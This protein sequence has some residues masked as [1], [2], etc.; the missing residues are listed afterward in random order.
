MHKS[1]ITGDIEYSIP[2]GVFCRP[3]GYTYDTLVYNVMIRDRD[4][5]GDGDKDK[6]HDSNWL[7]SDTLLIR[8]Q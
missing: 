8:C 3:L 5:D 1:A 4:D 2:F 6:A 7:L